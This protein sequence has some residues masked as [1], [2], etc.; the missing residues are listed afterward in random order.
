MF[1]RPTSDKTHFAAEIQAEIRA[2]A[3]KNR[4]AKGL[5]MEPLRPAF[6]SGEDWNGEAVAAPET[7]EY[8]SPNFFSR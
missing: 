2:K 6:G 8:N 3:S 7:Y 1:F 5:T 4:A